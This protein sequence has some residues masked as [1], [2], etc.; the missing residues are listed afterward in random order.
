[1]GTRTGSRSPVRLK[2]AEFQVEETRAQSRSEGTGL[3]LAIAR[4]VVQ[5]HGGR[6][7]A[8]NNNG[9]GAVFKFTLPLADGAPPEIAA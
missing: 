6:I 4:E 2:A 3:G 9:G 7:W 5:A 1:M 8:E